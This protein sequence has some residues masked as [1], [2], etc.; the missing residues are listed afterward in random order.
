MP[1][2]EFVLIWKVW[3][4]SIRENEGGAI[5]QKNNMSLFVE[6]SSKILKY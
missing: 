1:F 5:I 2:N 3:L 4:M 6:E